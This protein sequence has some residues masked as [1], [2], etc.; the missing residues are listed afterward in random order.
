VVRPTAPEAGPV[1][2]SP[3]T[4]MTPE[5]FEAQY[6]VKVQMA[7]DVT[8]KPQPLPPGSQI[9]GFET[10]PYQGHGPDIGP[11]ITGV[12]VQLPDYGGEAI[13]VTPSDLVEMAG[14]VVLPVAPVLI[15][16]ET[17]AG[18]SGFAGSVLSGASSGAI[19]SGALAVGQGKQPIDVLKSAGMGALIS[20]GVSAL[21]GGVFALKGYEQ[22][23][24][25]QRSLDRDQTVRAALLGSA[26]SEGP[27]LASE[28]VPQVAYDLKVP[29][30]RQLSEAD[31]EFVQQVE[32]PFTPT[33]PAEVWNI[34][35]QD[36]PKPKIT[37]DK[38]FYY[39]QILSG[40]KP[41]VEGGLIVTRDV[42]KVIWE[43]PY[44]LTHIGMSAYYPAEINVPSLGLAT[45][46]LSGA[47]IKT[48]M[49]APQMPSQITR[50]SLKS[51][52]VSVP[53]VDDI[54]GARTIPLSKAIVNPIL[55]SI[56]VTQQVQ[57]LLQQ[58]RTV[59]RSDYG[60]TPNITVPWLDWGP[61]SSKLGIFGKG[62]KGAWY[63]KI[64][65]VAGSKQARKLAKKFGF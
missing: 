3:E 48:A 13:P 53:R 23:L 10:T 27:D 55:S 40:E 4:P 2:P 64:N 12:K 8:G 31:K 7:P 51:S 26:S 35:T 6:G 16:G 25:V 43:P 28:E 44:D 20:G 49:S 65:P 57:V 22:N 19:I 47:V 58:T 59:P 52:N 18:L 46:I 62:A 42:E 9:V 36:L 61:S 11:Q 60:G 39:E 37:V 63:L 38:P 34:Q 41:G 1:T 56:A 14:I 50:F 32:N 29:A 30:L 24:A 15:G 45:G 54:L 33:K 21:V 17:A 5:D